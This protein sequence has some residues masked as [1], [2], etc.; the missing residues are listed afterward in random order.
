MLRGIN[1]QVLFED[2]E[3]RERFVGCLQY[4]RSVSQ[5]AIYGY[6]LMDNHVHLL[7]KEGKESIGQTMKRIGVSYVAWYNRKYKRSGHLFQD[8]FKSEAVDTD[9]YLLTVLC[10]IHQNPVKS[11]LT[12]R[13]EG[14]RWSSYGEYINGGKFVDSE[15]V[16]NILS[17]ERG[18][19]IAAFKKHMKEQVDERCL[20]IDV[21]TKRTDQE[22]THMIQNL[23][24]IRVPAELQKFEKGKR[25]EI[26]RS[27]KATAGVSTWQL[28]RLTGLSQTVIAR[29]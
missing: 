5:Y 3:D 28:A 23:A 26:L 7:M 1:K 6:C 10:Y 8:R 20:E 4:Y 27:M 25:N 22:V 11:G 17:P 29:A 21:A 16:L 24:N 15:F 9:A 13:V 12:G 14:Y 18:T 2:D 19:A